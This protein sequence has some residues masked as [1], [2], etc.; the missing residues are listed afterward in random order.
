MA[1]TTK[2]QIYE[3]AVQALSHTSYTRYENK[4]LMLIL[5]RFQGC[6]HPA[7]SKPLPDLHPR[8]A[9][10]PSET[11]QGCALLPGASQGALR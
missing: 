4:L 3:F 11:S 2:Q 5:A 8:G 7:D 9:D 10:Q 1:E 6:Y